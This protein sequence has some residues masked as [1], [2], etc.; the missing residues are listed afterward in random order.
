MPSDLWN[1]IQ[2][3]NA[4]L[5]DCFVTTNNFKVKISTSTQNETSTKSYVL[6]DLVFGY[7]RPIP[8]KWASYS[9][10]WA[11]FCHDPEIARIAI[12]RAA[13]L[14]SVE[15]MVQAFLK[16][17][18]TAWEA[19]SSVNAFVK[20]WPQGRDFLPLDVINRLD[21]KVERVKADVTINTAALNT[22]LLK[23]KIMA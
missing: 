1:K 10:E 3:L 20:A 8:Y 15:Q 14:E 19:V 5:S 6:Y 12:E 11:P 7:P 4:S 9:H 16:E 22:E 13:K 23:A 18:I 2:A 17:I 21:Q